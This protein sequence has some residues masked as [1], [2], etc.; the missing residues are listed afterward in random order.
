[1]VEEYSEAQL[2]EILDQVREWG[3]EFSES[4]YFEALTDEQKRESASIVMQFAEY[5][6]SYFDSPPSDWNQRRVEEC[7]VEV[8]PRK[9]TAGDSYFR[10]VAPVLVVFFA[11]LDTQGYLEQGDQLVE[12]VQEIENDIIEQAA[13]SDNWGMAKS[14]MMQAREDGV[15][16]TDQE[17]IETYFSQINPDFTLLGSPEEDE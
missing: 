7:C 4:R 15:D 1:M 17:E 9:V 11:F 6:F 14:W 10:S 16:L 12:T 2:E 8:M 13:D 5:M 3:R